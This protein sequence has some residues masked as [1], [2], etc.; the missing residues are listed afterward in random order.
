MKNRRDDISITPDLGVVGIAGIEDTRDGPLL[1]PHL[2]RRSDI[3]SRKAFAD[4]R[5]DKQLVQPRLQFAADSDL[6]VR[7]EVPDTLRNSS[8]LNVG[9][10]TAMLL[11]ERG[12][13][14]DLR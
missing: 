11:R 13:N 5:A 14:D 1:V 2:Q 10:G 9:I 6:D 7:P 3:R 4:T 8:D 12:G